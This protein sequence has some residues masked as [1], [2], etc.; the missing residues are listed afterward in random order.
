MTIHI[1]NRVLKIICLVLAASII[2]GGGVFGAVKYNQN[3]T[4][5]INGLKTEV[6]QKGEENKTLTE[7]KT[8]IS[9]NLEICNKELTELKTKF[10]VALSDKEKAQVAASKSAT[11][12]SKQKTAAQKAA[13]AQKTAETGWDNCSYYLTIAAQLADV[14]NN[15]KYYYKVANDYA[16]KMLSALTAG[17]TDSAWY[18]AEQSDLSYRKAESYESQVQS[19]LNILK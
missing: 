10:G 1:T 2:L 3:K 9:T 13:E 19:L 18:W 16:G 4:V 8:M 17:D 7:E 15:Q 11:E 5:E 12:A 14:L 6:S